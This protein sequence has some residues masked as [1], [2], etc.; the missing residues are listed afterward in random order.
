MKIK[1]LYILLLMP[2]LVAVC[3]CGRKEKTP[4]DSVPE[5]NV[6]EV[7]TDSI[8]LHKDFPGY[9]QAHSKADVVGEVS[10]RLLTQNFTSGS[11]V[12]KGQVLFTIESTKYRDAV[13]Q[14]AASLAS[15]ESQRD[16]YLSQSEAMKKAYE[17]EAVSKMELMQSQSSLRQAEASIRSSRA[18]LESART[19]LDKCTVRA[20]I[21]GYISLNEVSPGNYINGEGAPQK[22]AEIYDNSTFDAIFSIADDRYSALLGS[23]RGSGKALYA[24]MPLKFRTPLPHSYTADLYYVAPTVSASTGTLDLVGRVENKDNEL[25]D[26]MYVTVSLPYGIDSRAVIVKDAALSTDQLGKYLYV[27]NDSNRVVYTPV[28]VGPLYQDSLRVIEKGVI[29][30]QK[31]VTRALLTVRNGME[32]RPIMTGARK[33]R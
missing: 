19:M 32:V 4:A 16:Y 21:S 14:A 12:T 28:T 30:G 33:A 11:Y 5:I 13:D 27:V 1:R 6:A 24:G 20:P 17:K 18:R 10:G 25:R 15:A 23:D 8:V 29:P 26:G 31:Y 2:A 9:L 7:M 22:L 3:S